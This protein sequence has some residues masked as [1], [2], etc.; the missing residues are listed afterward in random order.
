MCEPSARLDPPTLSVDFENLFND[1]IFWVLE[2]DDKRIVFPMGTEGEK[3]F[4]GKMD[5]LKNFNWE[6]LI[7]ASSSASDAE[8]ICWKRSEEDC[9]D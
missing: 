5:N 4:M 9:L 3:A 7:K 8:F 6:S 2:S 1:D